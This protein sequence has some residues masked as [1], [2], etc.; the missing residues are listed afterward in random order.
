M[1]IQEW[2]KE[3]LVVELNDE[4]Q[5]SEDLSSLMD[6]LGSSPFDVVLNFTGVGFMNSSNIAALLRLRKALLA[7]KRRLILCDVNTHV[8]GIFLVTGLDK[9]F[10]FTRDV[11]TALATL[12]LAAEPAQEG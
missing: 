12:Q 11:A 2:S 10:D 4:P 5:L 9:L 3:I 8:W 1:S 6:R 7:A